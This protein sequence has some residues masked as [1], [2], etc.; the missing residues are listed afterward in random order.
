MCKRSQLTLSICTVLFVAIVLAMGLFFFVGAGTA[1]ADGMVPS[2]VMSDLAADP[3][4]IPAQW[5]QMAGSYDLELITIAEGKDDHL[6]VYVYQ[7]GCSEQKDYRASYIR[8]SETI[9]DAIA[10]KDYSL[11]FCDR[12]GVFYK[13][14]VNSFT[15]SHEDVRYYTVIQLLRPYVDGIDVQADYGNFVTQVPFSVNRQYRFVDFGDETFIEAV[16]IDTVVIT[17]KLVGHVVHSKENIINMKHTYMHF[18][19]FRCNHDINDLLEA[20]VSFNTQSYHY[21]VALGYHYYEVEHN[22][23][24]LYAKN[25]HEIKYGFGNKQHAQWNEIES[26]D[27]FISKNDIDSIYSTSLVNVY[28]AEKLTEQAK[29]DLRNMDWVLQFY[30]V[31]ERQWRQFIGPAAGLETD[32]SGCNVTDVTILRLKFVTNGITYNLGVVDNKQT[33]STEPSNESK[34]IVTPEEGTGWIW[35][36]ISLALLV[37]LVIVLWPIM[38]YIIRFIVWVLSLPIKAIKGI[39]EAAKKRKKEKQQK[40]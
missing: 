34:I 9:D 29:Q 1:S 32:Y 31:D 20:D 22:S 37:V 18:V 19:S 38:P 27:S 8:L 13:Y 23:V 11:V 4:F 10:P 25:E 14:Y 36:L 17:D 26:V 40:G 3:S 5:P 21:N 30:Q 12:Y 33:G 28:Q 16:D 39:G 7:P 35:T 24:T 2:A 6:Y 15:I